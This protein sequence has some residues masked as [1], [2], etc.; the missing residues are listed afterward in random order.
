M[1]TWKGDQQHGKIPRSLCRDPSSQRKRNKLSNCDGALNVCYKKY[2][3]GVKED[4][5]PLGKIMR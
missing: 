1:R 4:T 5:T 3:H 2:V